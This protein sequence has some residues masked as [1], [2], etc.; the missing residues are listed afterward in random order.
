MVMTQ[1]GLGEGEDT[2]L[3]RELKSLCL[4][5]DRSPLSARN[6]SKGS[7]IKEVYSIFQ[8]VS[9]G[10]PVENLRRTVLEGRIL[11][12]SSYETRRS[13]W[14][15]IH[16][17]YFTFNNDWVVRSLAYAS[18]EGINSPSFLSLAYLY[19]ALRDN[20]TF[21]FVTGPLWE[22]WEKRIV[23]VDRDDVLSF[24]EEESISN[25]II[26]RWYD[27]TKKKLASNMLSAL[28]DFGL[29]TGVR[30][31]KIQRPPIAQE[32]VFHLLSILMSEGLKGHNIINAPDWRL[33]LWSGADIAHAL[34]DLSIRGWI[35]FEKT[36]RTVLIE[37]KRLPE[38]GK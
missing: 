1:S 19:Y 38:V 32:T 6:S 26:D 28:R 18:R 13:I 24:L 29:L 10:L 27:S 33:F 20:L 34:N 2:P 15:H 7:L 5:R 25:P 16:R 22:K 30:R 36:G 12:H 37:L 11:L 9:N 17:R 23:T 8:A 14:N 35:G 4:V 3:K 21:K 31:K